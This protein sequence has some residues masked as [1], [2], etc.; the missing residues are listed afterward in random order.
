MKLL[1]S[2]R[3]IWRNKRKS[4]EENLEYY[5]AG[6]KM[7]TVHYISFQIQY[8]DLTCSLGAH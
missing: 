8:M 3:C 5:L 4:E 7:E 2:I 6:N 1:W